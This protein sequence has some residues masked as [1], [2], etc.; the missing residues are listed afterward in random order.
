MDSPAEKNMM[1]PTLAISEG[2]KR[3]PKMLTHRSAPP[4]DLPMPGTNT[5]AISTMDPPSANTD[6]QRKCW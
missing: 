2:W 5:S 6:I 1:T 4:P 3:M